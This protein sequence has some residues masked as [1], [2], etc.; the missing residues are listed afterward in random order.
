MQNISFKNRIKLLKFIC[1]VFNTMCL[2]MLVISGL[3]IFYTAYDFVSI[4]KVDLL[5]LKT[6][7]ILPLMFM[8]Y[9]NGKLEFK[10]RSYGL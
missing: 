6:L 5:T 2:V 10:Y 9:L 7:I 3:I 8:L 1:I 4:G